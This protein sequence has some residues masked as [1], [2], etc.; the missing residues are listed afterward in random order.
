MRILT[1]ADDFGMDDDTVRATIECLDAGALTGATIMPNMPATA[2]AVGYARAH[3]EKSFGVHLTFVTDTVEAPLCPPESLPT[4]A[5]ASG[6]F[7]PS[8]VVRVNALRGRIAVDE[9]AR[10]TAAQIARLVDQGV[11]VSH[12]DSHGHLHKFKPFRLALSA[13]LPRFG[14]TRVR[15]VQDVYLKRPL[16]SPTFWLGGWW[17]GKIMRSFATTDHFFMPP[18]ESAETAWVPRLLSR[19]TDARGDGTLEV[20]V[21][22]GYAETWREAERRAIVEFADAAR[23]AGHR[24]I[25]W[26]DL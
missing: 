2:R 16:K 24:L 15:N 11:R 7:L 14:I 4:L 19:F 9:I 3:P 12:V 23:A 18:P 26:A 17:R 25:G 8:Q 22:P 13:V 5:D 1:N 6:R 10:E 21:H 20:G